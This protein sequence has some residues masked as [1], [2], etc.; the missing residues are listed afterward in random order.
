MG[1]NNSGNLA[2]HGGQPIVKQRSRWSW[3]PRYPGLGDLVKNYI[4]GGKPISIQDQS[5]IIKEVEDELK[6]RF[7][8][9]HAICFPESMQ[10]TVHL[11]QWRY[12]VL[13][14]REK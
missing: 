2:I 7:S 8:R 4:D 13:F 11:E 1:I 12:T 5:G 3:P 14:L 9:K 6:R 10:F